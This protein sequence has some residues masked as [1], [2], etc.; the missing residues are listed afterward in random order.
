MGGLELHQFKSPGLSAIDLTLSPGECVSL[1]GPSGC[2]KT[3][4]LR[5]IADLDPNEGTATLDE[6]PRSEIPPTDWR[7]QVGYLPTE[8]HW[9]ASR[10]GH[11]FPD[12]EEKAF[13]TLG[14]SMECLEWEV[15]RLSSGERQR[16]AL[17]R[18]LAHSPRILLLD[19]PTA[20]LDQENISRVESLISQFIEEQGAAV[21]WVSHDP[22]QRKRV[23]QR[24][25]KIENG[26]LETEAW[27]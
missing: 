5:A 22:A 8:S 27:N 6:I 9:W 1:T 3:R 24:H 20:N 13:T 4:L 15:T 2:G 21:L 12:G 14:F 11:H 17:V 7:S 25:M 18:L 16:L 26:K 10:V 23:A 19:E